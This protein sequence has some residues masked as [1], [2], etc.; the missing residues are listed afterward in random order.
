MA[1]Q[2][3]ATLD[4]VLARYLQA[5][6]VVSQQELLKFVRWCGRERPL[7]ELTP[8]EVEDY[9][10]LIA[11]GP[12]AESERRLTAVRDFLL[13]ARKE[14]FVQAN[15]AT[16]LKVRRSSKKPK[17][18]S[19]AVSED[20]SAPAH[21]TT[22]GRKQMEERLGWLREEMVRVADEIHKAAADKDV[23]E[24]APLEAAREYQGQLAARLRE[25]ETTLNTAVVL[26]RR[27]DNTGI[28]RLGS[29][30]TLQ[31]VGTGETL[32]YMLVDP[33]EASLLDGKI[34]TGSPVGRAL[35]GRQEGQ[36][37]QVSVPRG[38]LRY[39]VLRVE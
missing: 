35:L 23:R 25:L 31:D 10:Q 8:P 34:S 20:A 26:T 12:A 4:D 14:G 18:A 36:E 39:R 16:H 28:V 21:L 9:A 7:Q 22:E 1:Q 37:L 5:H 6:G 29:R 2:H 17:P 38:S 27:E 33:R 13:F 30:I 15:L 11:L 32:T 3:A 19:G 24:N